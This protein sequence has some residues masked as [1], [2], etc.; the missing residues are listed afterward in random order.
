M[1][2]DNYF[3]GSIPVG[4]FSGLFPAQGGG[5]G[6][7]GSIDASCKATTG[8]AVG[9]ALQRGRLGTLSGAII[10]TS[11]PDSGRRQKRYAATV[12]AEL[13]TIGCAALGRVRR[14]HNSRVAVE[15][16]RTGA[17][18]SGFADRSALDEEEL[19]LML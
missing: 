12:E 1:N 15:A 10:T 8:Q 3:S 19:L 13:K 4:Y 17:E 5:G 9:S 2:L 16:G 7:T 11:I 18:V 6:A 14:Y